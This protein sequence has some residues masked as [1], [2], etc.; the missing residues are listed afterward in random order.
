VGLS[1]ANKRASNGRNGKKNLSKEV[2]E[3]LKDWFAQ[4]YE[5]CAFAVCF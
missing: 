3:N 4:H 5:W 1:R 2:V